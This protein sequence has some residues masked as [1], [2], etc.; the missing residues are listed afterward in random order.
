[1]K[2]AVFPLGSPIT[3]SINGVEFHVSE[4][5]SIASALLSADIAE[6]RRT[7]RSASPR[8]LFCGMGSCYDCVVTVDGAVQRSCITAIADGMAIET[9][10]GPTK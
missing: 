4:G 8:G 2:R 6:F 9:T 1:M 5:A 7:S 10:G 3:I